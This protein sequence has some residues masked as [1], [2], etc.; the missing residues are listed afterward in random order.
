ML[1]DALALQSDSLSVLAMARSANIF[2]ISP[3]WPCQKTVLGRAMC[4]LTGQ[5]NGKL[6]LRLQINSF[7]IAGAQVLSN[8]GPTIHSTGRCA[9]KLRSAGEFER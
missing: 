2:H 7:A 8:H 9:I 1:R 5:M 6:S 4:S 3:P